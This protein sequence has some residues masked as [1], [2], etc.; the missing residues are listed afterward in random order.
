MSHGTGG[1]RTIYGIPKR[2]IKY[3]HHSLSN[4]D[5]SFQ[6]IITIQKYQPNEDDNIRYG[7]FYEKL[8]TLRKSKMD[9]A[10]KR[11]Y[12]IYIC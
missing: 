6:K 8:P 3:P 10:W 2:F 12:Q 7:E 5:M 1:I 11:S 9:G 4:L